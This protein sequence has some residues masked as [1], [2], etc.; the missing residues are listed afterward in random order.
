LNESECVPAFFYTVTEN[1]CQ[2]EILR[3][4]SARCGA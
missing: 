2:G 4:K 1:R 3:E